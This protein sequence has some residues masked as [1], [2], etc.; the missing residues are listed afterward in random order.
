MIRIGVARFLVVTLLAATAAGAAPT[1]RPSSR[2][3][4]MPPKSEVDRLVKPLIDGQWVEGLVVGLIGE[5][6]SKVYGYGRVSQKDP[7]P[8]G[9]DTVFEIGSLTKAYTGVLL[10]LMA[11]SKE[12][13]LDDPVRK[14]LPPAVRAPHRDDRPI[15]LR[16]LSTH[17]SG[18][19]RMPS[20]FT[21]KDQAN[22]YADYTVEQMYAF[23]S[24]CE[25]DREPGARY[26]YSNLGAGLLGH[27]LSLQAGKGGAYEPLV[28]ERICR[29]L[30]LKDTRIAL[31]DDMRHRLA[32]GHDPDGNPVANWDL[33]TL[34]GAGALRSTA[35]DQL[36]FVAANLGL[37]EPKGTPAERARWRA[38]VALSHARHTKDGAGADVGLGWHIDLKLGVRWHNGQTGGY[39]SYVGF[40]PEKRVGVVMLTNT[41]AGA[42][43]TAGLA[44]LRRWLGLSADPPKLRTAVPLAADTLD[45]YTGEYRLAPFV[46]LSVTREGDKLFAQLTGQP[47]FRIYPESETKFFWKVVDARATFE[48]DAKADGGKAVKLTLHQHGQNV[49]APRVK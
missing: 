16:H 29:P 4:E 32:V 15:T 33:P 9:G 47:P 6:G 11:E 44:L 13:S 34:A 24:D 39:H 40:H 3:A 19:P 26:E 35:E 48:W 27:L 21:P 18:L 23:L 22:P 30:G 7:R 20:N 10:A 1:T 31:T 38:A 42:V 36:K 12:V 14:Y 46:T 28:L 5:S 2:P 41:G 8:P 45:R 37:L 25:P 17:T 49:P 43:D